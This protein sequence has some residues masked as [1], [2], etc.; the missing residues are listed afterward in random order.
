MQ[1]AAILSPTPTPAFA[2]CRPDD[3]QT[4]VRWTL[5]AVLS[6][7]S[8]M[9]RDVDYFLKQSLGIYFCS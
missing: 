7:I 9:A 2:I 8:M 3:D 1:Q 4:L 5:K 6:Y